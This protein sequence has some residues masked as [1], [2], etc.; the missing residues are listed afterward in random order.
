LQGKVAKVAKVA[1]FFSIPIWRP[2]W[3]PA[4]SALPRKAR[5]RVDFAFWHASQP[6]SKPSE[7]K[8]QSVTKVVW[9]TGCLGRAKTSECLAGKLV[10]QYES[11]LNDRPWW[12]TTQP[13]TRPLRLV[14]YR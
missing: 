3:S 5:W 4:S 1:N 10:G 2:Y 9:M 6:C 13:T 12:N 7:P 8:C 14:S 11:G